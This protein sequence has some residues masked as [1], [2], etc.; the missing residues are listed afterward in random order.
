MVQED[1]TASGSSAAS[2]TEAEGE[3]SRQVAAHLTPLPTPPVASSTATEGGVVTKHE[4]RIYLPALPFPP[5]LVDQHS[6]PVVAAPLSKDNI[7]LLPIN[8]A[9]TLSVQRKNAHLVTYTIGYLYNYRISILPKC[10]LHCI[11]LASALPLS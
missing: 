3:N 8:D 5:L 1:G 2:R 4:K 11:V 9:V 7:M 10:S 6:Q